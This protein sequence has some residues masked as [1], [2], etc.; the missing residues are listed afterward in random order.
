MKKIYLLASVAFTMNA[1]AQLNPTPH[2]SPLYQNFGSTTFTSNPSGFVNGKVSGTPLTTQTAA[3]TSTASAPATLAPTTS[4][5][6]TGGSFGLANSGNGRMYLQHSASTTDGTNQLIMAINTLNWHNVKISFDVEM[7]S[8]NLR[9]AGLILQ[10]R[11]GT[12]GAWTNIAGGIYSHSISDRINGQ[13][14]SYTNLALPAAAAN[15]PVVQLRWATWR[16]TQTGNSSGIAVDNVNISASPQGLNT[17][18]SASSAPSC[19]EFFISEYVHD[20]TVNRAIEIYNPTGSSKS[21]AGYYLSITTGTN[22]ATYIT[23]SGTVQSYSTFV[24][25]NAKAGAAILAKANQFV[26]NFNYSG[27]D[28]IDL[29]Y[30]TN[31]MVSVQIIDQIGDPT[32]TTTNGFT[33]TALGDTGT[34]K[35]HT[36]T[37]LMNI[38]RGNLEWVSAQHE[39]YAHPVNTYGFL[40]WHSNSCNASSMPTVVFTGSDPSENIYNDIGVNTYHPCT[41]NVS[42]TGTW[43]NQFFVYYD[44]TYNYT[45]GINF[46]L[47]CYTP[48]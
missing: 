36:L 30:S 6:T 14:D 17:N 8:A 23:L 21:L 3:Q 37:R 41:F 16:G 33:V 19:S 22:A 24:V 28:V 27:N 48:E 29:V 12:T 31:P 39:W 38:P 43:S 4:V 9:T 46:P 25:A 34:T 13:I 35:N 5:Q 2:L 20:T 26:P 47:T 1:F 11:I 32:V 44:D 10:Y 18:V 42:I 15:Q 40:G 7:I 45:Q